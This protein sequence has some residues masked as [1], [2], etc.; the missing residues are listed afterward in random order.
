MSVEQLNFISNASNSQ[1]YKKKM[2]N[3]VLLKSVK[4]GR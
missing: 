4:F 2:L 1:N 3:F